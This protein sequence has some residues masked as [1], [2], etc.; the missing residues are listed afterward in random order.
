MELAQNIQSKGVDAG[1][2]GTF[3]IWCLWERAGKEGDVAVAGGVL[4]EAEGG[5]EGKGGGH[6]EGVGVQDDAGIAAA[7]DAGEGL[8]GE[9]A[10]EALAAEVRVNEEAFD[11]GGVLFGEGCGLTVGDAGGGSVVDCSEEE[12]AVVGGVR[13]REG[14]DLFVVAWKVDEAGAAL[15][16][17]EEVA[18][19]AEEGLG[20]GEVR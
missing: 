2:A 14:A 15:C 7:G 19:E 18:V 1:G 3:S 5:V 4:A 17:A 16:G 12:F 10:G 9:C 20:L 13:V 11:L 6:V 8:L